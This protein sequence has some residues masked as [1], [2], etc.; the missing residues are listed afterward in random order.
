MKQFYHNRTTNQEYCESKREPIEI[1]FNYRPDF[2]T[3]PACQE[4]LYEL[5]Y[6]ELKVY[7]ILN[8]LWANITVRIQK[9][10]IKY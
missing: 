7:G 10:K 9:W 8:Y 6:K 2:F 1:F 5:F 4:R 3:F